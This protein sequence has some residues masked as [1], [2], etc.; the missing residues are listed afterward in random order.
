M[1]HDP[2]I[3][4]DDEFEGFSLQLIDYDV[5]DDFGQPPAAIV[6][7]EAT[8]PNWGDAEAFMVEAA[9]HYGEDFKADYVTFDLTV[10]NKPPSRE[11]KSVVVDKRTN[12]MAL[13]LAGDWCETN[14]GYLPDVDHI[15]S[16]DYAKLTF[17][18]QDDAVLYQIRWL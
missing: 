5:T 7:V 14:L 15:G 13:Y 17:R 18:S 8:F 16:Q 10:T 9:K 2:Y 11:G 12:A 1:T 4:T 6:E 3:F